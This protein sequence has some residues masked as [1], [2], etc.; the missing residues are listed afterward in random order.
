MD[1]IDLLALW[2]VWGAAAVVL[3][4]GEVL[5]PRERANG[6]SSA[7]CE[8]KPPGRCVGRGLLL[9]ATGLLPRQQ[10]SSTAAAHSARR[11]GLMAAVVTAC[12]R[13]RPANPVHISRQLPAAALLPLTG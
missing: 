3:A 1:I 8:A 5:L 10:C 13:G 4:V 12:V 11:C 2:W 6:S 7:A 9:A